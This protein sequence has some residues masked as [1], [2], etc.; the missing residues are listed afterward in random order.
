LIGSKIYV[1]Y[2]A[3][4][5]EESIKKTLNEIKNTLSHET[6]A[7]IVNKDVNSFD[8][9]ILLNNKTDKIKKVTDW[10]TK[11][12][13]FFSTFSSFFVSNNVDLSKGI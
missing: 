9:T 5:F 3:Y 13:K 7:A 8:K 12:K 11:V 2:T 10:S 4:K 1:D 6:I